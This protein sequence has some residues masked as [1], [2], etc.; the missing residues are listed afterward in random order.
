MRKGSLL[1]EKEAMTQE[2]KDFLREKE[3]HDKAMSDMSAKLTSANEESTILKKHLAAKDIE[4][5]KLRKENNTLLSYFL[6]SQALRVASLAS[7]EP[8]LYNHM[9]TLLN[10]I[11]GFYP[12]E[13]K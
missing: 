2:H 3:E 10:Y 11:F 5:K 7:V 1:K 9:H 6:S 13:P 12:F 4:V 8:T